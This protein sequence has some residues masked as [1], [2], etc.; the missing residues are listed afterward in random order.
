[1]KI[2]DSLP[3]KQ[4]ESSTL[5]DCIEGSD[6]YIIAERFGS[7]DEQEYTIIACNNF[8]KSIELLKEVKEILR[9]SERFDKNIRS[10]AMKIKIDEFLNTLEDVR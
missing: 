3:W 6:E 7:D 5:Q 9:Q 10:L 2:P 4:V 8:P 1:M